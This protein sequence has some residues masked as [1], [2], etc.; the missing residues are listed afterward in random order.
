[1]NNAAEVVTGIHHQLNAQD[2]AKDVPCW[3]VDMSRDWF[4]QWAEGWSNKRAFMRLA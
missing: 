3:S 1:M 2:L 4:R